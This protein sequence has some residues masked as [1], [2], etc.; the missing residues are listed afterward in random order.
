MLKYVLVVAGLLLIAGGLAYHFAALQLLNLLVPKDAGVVVAARDVAYGSASRQRYDVYRPEGTAQHPLLIFVY[1]G[2]WASGDKA[3]YDFVARAFAARGFV[4]V[5]SDYRLVPQNVYPDFVDDVG[6]AIVHAMREAHAWGADTSQSFVVGHSAGAYN[7][8]QAIL[9]PAFRA[10][11]GLDHSRIAAVATLAGPFD[12]L[13][14]DVPSTVNAFGHLNTAGLKD[15]QVFEHVSPDAPPFLILHGEA[16]TTVLL[17]SPHALH[18]A[19]NGVGATVELKTYPSIS[20]VRILLALAKP[21]RKDPPVLEDIL[22]FF[23]K[24]KTP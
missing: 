7:L 8:T 23:A 14:L 21:W 9:H 3:P 15:T 18:K 24:H 22:A 11:S 16:D 10:K 12:F 20:H 17:R 13:P 19:M 1:G 4:V 6:L 5:V 2:S